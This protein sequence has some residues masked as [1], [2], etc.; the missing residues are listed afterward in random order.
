M[1]LLHGRGLDEILE[2]TT[3]ENQPS[4]WERTEIML[5]VTKAVAAMHRCGV[6]HRD[7]ALSNIWVRF[8]TFFMV[9]SFAVYLNEELR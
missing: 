2:D 3:L 7:I 1:P 5:G 8:S 4:D 9:F 6:L